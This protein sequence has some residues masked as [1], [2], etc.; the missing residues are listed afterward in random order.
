MRQTNRRH[1][2]IAIHIEDPCER[3]LPDVGMLALEDAE[4]GDL[5]ELDT[6]DPAVREHFN[7]QADER[8]EHLVRDFRSEG[9]DTLELKTSAPYLPVLQRFFRSRGRKHS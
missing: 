3:R 8:I 1:D 4:T 5:I 2:L 7:R 6:A 9:I